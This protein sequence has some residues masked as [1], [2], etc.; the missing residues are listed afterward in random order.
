MVA[1]KITSIILELVIFCSF[2]YCF[3]LINLKTKR[4]LATMEEYHDYLIQYRLTPRSRILR[5]HLPKMTMVL[6]EDSNYDNS[7]MMLSQSRILSQR[8]SVN[9]QPKKFVY[10]DEEE[11][12]GLELDLPISDD[13]SL[14]DEE[15]SQTDDDI[16]R[17]LSML[18]RDQ[19]DY[20]RRIN[21]LSAK[22]FTSVPHSD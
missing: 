9:R 8:T 6:E 15:T 7:S 2:L 3:A 17:D 5:K 4:C 18:D 10:R 22:S 12:T 20:I 11:G 16:E 19:A 14:S 21:K 1:E 13:D